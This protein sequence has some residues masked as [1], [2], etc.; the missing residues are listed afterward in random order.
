MNLTGVS[1]KCLHF[2]YVPSLLNAF[3]RWFHLFWQAKLCLSI[4]AQ[5][6]TFHD[7]VTSAYQHNSIFFFFCCFWQRDNWILPFDSDS[8]FD[9]G[10]GSRP[11]SRPRLLGMSH[12]PSEEIKHWLLTLIKMP[13]AKLFISAREKI[14]FLPI[15]ADQ[16]TSERVRL[17]PFIFTA[18]SHRICSA[19]K[20]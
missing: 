13:G 18:P 19:W 2:L 4:S 12:D 9:V 7:G 8:S 14:T 11:T 3:V 5:S 20:I 17:I 6:S 16:Q 15:S 1:D 10:D